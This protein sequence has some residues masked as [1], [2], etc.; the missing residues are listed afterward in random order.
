LSGLWTLYLFVVVEAAHF[1]LPS[2]VP[3]SGQVPVRVAKRRRFLRI[4]PSA[5][6]DAPHPVHMVAV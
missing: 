2:K 1:S 4:A 5:A 3:D 6:R